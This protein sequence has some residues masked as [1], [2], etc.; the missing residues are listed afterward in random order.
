VKVS[1]LFIARLFTLIKTILTCKLA[2]IAMVLYEPIPCP[3]IEEL[4]KHLLTKL[5]ARW[6]RSSFATFK[7][8][9]M[10]QTGPW[11][12]GNTTPTSIEFGFSPEEVLSFQDLIPHLQQDPRDTEKGGHGIQLHIMQPVHDIEQTSQAQER[13]MMKL[14]KIEESNASRDKAAVPQRQQ[15]FKKGTAKRIK[16]EHPIKEMKTDIKKEKKVS[17]R[18]T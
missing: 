18:A 1:S 16:T 4:I 5:P 3:P 15:K 8:D 6:L 12:D 14:E 13:E 2:A 10:L 11:K 17:Y 7:P 9:F